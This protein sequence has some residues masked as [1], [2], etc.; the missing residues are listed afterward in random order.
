MDEKNFERENRKKLIISLIYFSFAIILMLTIIFQFSRR[1]DYIWVIIEIIGIII[2]IL[3]MFAS[4]V[5]NCP[6]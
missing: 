6:L 3:G 4:L 1:G 5:L 2:A